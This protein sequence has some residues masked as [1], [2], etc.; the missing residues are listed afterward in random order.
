MVHQQQNSKITNQK[1]IKNKSKTNQKQIKNK[2]KT[3][4]IFIIR[5]T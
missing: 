4:N 3:I 1:Q 2:S 5:F